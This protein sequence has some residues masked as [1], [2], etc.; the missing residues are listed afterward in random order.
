MMKNVKRVV[1]QK[2]PKLPFQKKLKQNGQLAP[3][4]FSP[5]YKYFHQHLQTVK[6]ETTVQNLVFE[7]FLQTSIPSLIFI[8]HEK[9][10]VSRLSVQNFCLIVPKNFVG[11]IQC[12]REFRV[13]KSFLHEKGLSRFCDETFFVSQYRKTS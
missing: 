9:E 4:Y 3:A 12:I 11:A 2:Q 8:F 5:E 7:G 10:G 6:N 1:W 13:R